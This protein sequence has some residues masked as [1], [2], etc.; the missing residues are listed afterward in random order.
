[1]RTLMDIAQ[2]PKAELHCHSDGILSPAMARM[3]RL[4]HPEFVIDPD[5]LEHAYP[6]DN[7]T[8]FFDW[9]SYI[10]ALDRNL[11]QYGW[12]MEQYIAQQKKQHVSYLEIF[13]ANGEI[14]HDPAE[15]VDAMHTFRAF[16]DECEADEIQV[17]FV[18]TIGRGQTAERFAT[19]ESKIL[20]LFDAGLIAGVALAGPE[21]GNPASKFKRSFARFHTAGLPIEI[22]AGEWVGAESVWDALEHCHP[23]RI[24]HGVTLFDDPRL[25]ELF[26]ER[27]IHLEIC[28]TSNVRTGSVA[29]FEDHPVQRARDLGL[30]F[31]VNTDDPGI[32]LCSMNSEYEAITSHFNFTEADWQ[33][34]YQNSMAARFQRTLRAPNLNQS[35]FLSKQV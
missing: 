3:I 2:L 21:I 24:G 35:M 25:I 20:T 13:L 26:Q 28:P 9:Q 10:H 5:A 6:I 7:I 33:K 34:V 27:Q 18:V 31:S 1:M 4:K 29:R 22:H 17:E 32:F 19:F 16:V 11:A 30:N 14:P 12:V 8:S 23:T 15:A